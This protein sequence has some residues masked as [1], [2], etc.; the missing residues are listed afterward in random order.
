[1]FRRRPLRAALALGCKS[2]GGTDTGMLSDDEVRAEIERLRAQVD[3]LQIALR[4]REKIG[5]AVGILMATRKCTQETA[6]QSLVHA[7]QRSNR[8]LRDI[9]DVVIWTGRLSEADVA[10]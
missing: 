4:T 9:A 3:N 5:V 7:S 10:A 8:K 1:M 6:F 2:L